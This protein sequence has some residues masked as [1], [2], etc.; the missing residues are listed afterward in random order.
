MN[1]YSTG[2]GL[3][4]HKLID[5]EAQRDLRTFIADPNGYLYIDQDGHQ[6]FWTHARLKET[7]C[8]RKGPPIF[9]KLPG[10]GPKQ[11][12]AQPPR[13]I[14]PLD[15]EGTGGDGTGEGGKGTGKGTGKKHKAVPSSSIIPKVSP[16]TM[17]VLK[18]AVPSSIPKPSSRAPSSTFGS[19][20]AEVSVPLPKLLL[21][22]RVS[23]ASD[24]EETVKIVESEASDDR[25]DVPP[26]MEIQ[27]YLRNMEYVDPNMPTEDLDSPTEDLDSPTEQ[28]L[29]F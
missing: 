17:P 9:T 21:L 14:Y 23:E 6:K 24:G 10:K 8:R 25:E 22:G 5:S 2:V 1:R 18:K 3:I 20:P 26:T 12:Q 11:P 29:P 15:G 4:G 28:L 27:A 13:P 19:I 16:S 7:H